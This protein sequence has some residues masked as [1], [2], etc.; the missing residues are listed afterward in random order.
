MVL[1]FSLRKMFFFMV[2]NFFCNFFFTTQNYH[3]GLKIA[4]FLTPKYEKTMYYLLFSCN[5]K[6]SKIYNKIKHMKNRDCNTRNHRHGGFS[7]KPS[8]CNFRTRVIP[9]YSIFGIYGM[10][11]TL[12]SGCS[13]EKKSRPYL[14][15]DKSHVF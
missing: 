4:P 11:K 1:F 13:T 14:L 15:H 7:K 8:S 2:V 12:D 9:Y 5:N 6:D 3:T 10:S